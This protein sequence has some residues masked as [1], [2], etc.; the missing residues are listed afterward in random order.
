MAK[1]IIYTLFLGFFTLSLQAEEKTLQKSCLACHK[2]E[3]IP[4]EMIYKRYLMKYSTISRMEGA[5]YAYLKNPRKENSIMPEAFF[6]K[7]PMKKRTMD[8]DKMLRTNIR[9][10]LEHFDIGKRLINE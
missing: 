5:I 9:K 3:K 4:S 2:K 7:F 6:S 1:I 10:Y 8:D